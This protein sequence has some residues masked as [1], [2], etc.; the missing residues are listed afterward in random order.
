MLDFSKLPLLAEVSTL[1][2]AK[3]QV[4]ATAESCTGGLIS[5]AI[6]DLSGSSSIFD[7]SFV[8]YSNQA[9]MDMLGVHEQT[10]IDFGAVSAETAKEMVLGALKNS[11]ATIAIA[12]TGIAG[13]TGG[14]DEKPVGLV[15]TACCIDRK[16][17]KIIE[18]HFDGTRQEIRELTLI[19][20]LEMVKNILH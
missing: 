11:N 16:Q 4:L 18:N 1:L 3:K 20:T 2:H 17:P 13:P 5:A 8:T 14:T 7:R 10:L 19:K 9:K 15:Y 6:T 12:V